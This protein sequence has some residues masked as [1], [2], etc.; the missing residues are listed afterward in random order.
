M[1]SQLGL[2]L[3]QNRVAKVVV[4][5]V[6]SGWIVVEFKDGVM[7]KRDFLYECDERNDALSQQHV[8]LINTEEDFV[9]F[10]PDGRPLNIEDDDV[11][12]APVHVHS[13]PS[14]DNGGI[15]PRGVMIRWMP[16]VNGPPAP[17][18]QKM[19]VPVFRDTIW[20]RYR[21]TDTGVFRQVPYIIVS[22]LPESIGA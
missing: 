21:V 12:T 18:E 9:L 5:V 4:S 7:A 6:G 8:L 14:R 2:F 20:Q 3:G 10:Q 13:T 19:F 16:S 15:R 1:N 22:K 17:T 11:L